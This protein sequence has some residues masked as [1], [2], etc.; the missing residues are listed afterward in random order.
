MELFP[1]FEM[2][3]QLMTTSQ[4]LVEVSYEIYRG[5]SEKEMAGARCD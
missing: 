3:W 4:L 5:F 1:T 2:L